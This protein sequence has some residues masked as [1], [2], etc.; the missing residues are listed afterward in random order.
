MP[1][2]TVKDFGWG[3]NLQEPSTLEDNQFE[4]LL[5]MFYD[6]DWRLRS[7][8]WIWLFWNPIPWNKPPTSW[9]FYKN[10]TT[11][12]R[13]AL[14]SSWE[15]VF[16]YNEWTWAWVSIKTWLTEFET[17]WV[18]RTRWSFAVY[19]NKIYLCNWIDDYAEYDSATDTYTA[20]ASQPKVRYL[21]FLW[22]SIYWAW[23]DLNPSMLYATDAGAI[24]WRTLDA[25]E[26][27]VWW[28]EFWRINWLEELQ[29]EVLAFKNKKIYSVP[30]DLT[31]ALPLDAENGWYWDRSIQRVWNSLVYFN[32]RGFNTLQAKSGIT[33][34]SAIQ[35]EPL[36]DD[37]RALTSLTKP[38]QYNTT[39]WSYIL[40]LTNYYWMFDTSWDD[41]PDTTLVYSSLQKSWAQ[42]NWPSMYS[43]WEYEDE[44][45][46]IHYIWTSATSWQVFELESWLDDLWLAIDY[47]LKTKKYDFGDP[48]EW[49][50]HTAVDLVW[51]KSPWDDI[52]VSILVDW[53]EVW[54]STITDDFTNPTSD[55]LPIWTSPIWIGAIWWG[56]IENGWIN[57]FQYKIRVP[58]YESWSNIQVILTA[59]S[60]SLI[61]TLDKLN[62]H[63]ENEDV[64][65]FEFANIW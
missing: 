2:A 51:L 56:W 1:K 21:A 42:Y 55:V 19:L 22:D 5:N 16:K 29:K 39:I 62:L 40:P 28:E 41:K 17:D 35:D 7:R 47:K 13:T 9:F 8:A 10:P 54:W 45:G 15:D 24:D 44:D 27:L 6:S 37:V 52:E 32:D 23:E 25:N 49:D 26:V 33:W 57:L 11:L 14:V 63:Y 64:D 58:M 36:S 61:F 59:S 20:L 12:L 31:S 53:N 60:K 3:L 50:T 34:V 30:W 65:L 46:I 43:F 4:E 18:T 38:K 48:T